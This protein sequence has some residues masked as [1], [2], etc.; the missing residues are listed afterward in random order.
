MSVGLPLITL[1]GHGYR[2]SVSPLH[3]ASLTE[4]TWQATTGEVSILRACD[5]STLS[6]G[7]PGPVSCFV[8]APFANRIDGGV[9]T[10]E[11]C[12]H[13][14][15]INRPEEN[16]AIH[17]L[18]RLAPFEIVDHTDN[19]AKLLHR[20][21]GD[22][23]AYD[24]LQTLQIGTRGVHIGL[25]LTNRDTKRMPFGIGLHPFFVRDEGT[26]L[27][28]RARVRFVSD[29]RNLPTRAIAAADGPDF[30]QGVLLRDLP[31]FDSHYTQWEPRTALLE[32]PDAGL[33]VTISAWGAFRNLHVFTPYASDFICIEPVSHVPDVANRRQF[34]PLGDLY[35]LSPGESLSGTFAIKAEGRLSAGRRPAQNAASCK[36]RE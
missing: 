23:F 7:E 32:R 28:F 25:R 14:L 33:S 17:G 30:R 16:V 19:S 8:M 22:V 6:V 26:R 29:N 1:V 5:A 3:G 12:R 13:A 18:S 36:Q 11:G 34:S 4:L 15:P 31:W 10:H 2:L 9:F 24:L 27:T 21:R 35:F 20:H